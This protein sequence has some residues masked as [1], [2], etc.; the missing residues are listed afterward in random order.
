MKQVEFWRLEVWNL[1]GTKEVK[2]RHHMD[3]ATALA[4]HPEAIR[5]PGSMELREIAET[6]EELADRFN[7]RSDPGRALPRP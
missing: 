2:T 5:V 1:Q 4:R 3:E 6:D 7:T